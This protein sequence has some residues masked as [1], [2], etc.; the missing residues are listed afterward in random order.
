MEEEEEE[1]LVRSVLVV[2][3]IEE[4]WKER[5]NRVELL[6]EEEFVWFC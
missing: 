6:L 5:E 3:G 1:G 2:W 4:G